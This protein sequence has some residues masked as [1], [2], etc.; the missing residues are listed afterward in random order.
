MTKRATAHPQN[1]EP[2]HPPGAMIASSFTIDFCDH[3]YGL[4]SLFMEGEEEPFA[5][6][7]FAPG[8]TIDLAHYFASNVRV[9][10]SA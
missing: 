5:V 8:S 4:L 2:R 1:Y 7:Y 9:E 10:G 3:G 6:A